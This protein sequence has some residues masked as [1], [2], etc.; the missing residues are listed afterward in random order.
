[1]CIDKC[2]HESEGV[3]MVSIQVMGKDEIGPGHS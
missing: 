1:M 3:T 2:G